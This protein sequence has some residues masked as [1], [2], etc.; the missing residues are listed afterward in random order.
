MVKALQLVHPYPYMYGEATSF[1]IVTKFAFEGRVA[2][3]DI[4]VRDT[5]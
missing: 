5:L 1:V 2:S 3:I 4:K